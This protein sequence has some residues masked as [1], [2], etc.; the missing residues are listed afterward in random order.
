MVL[1]ACLIQLRPLHLPKT[2]ETVPERWQLAPDPGVLN[3]PGA[4]PRSLTRQKL[5]PGAARPA[6]WLEA[7]AQVLVSSG[8]GLLVRRQ[9]AVATAYWLRN[10]HPQPGATASFCCCQSAAK[11][12]SLPDLVLQLQV[13][14]LAGK[15]DASGSL[16][17]CE[18]TIKAMRSRAFT[19]ACL[20]S[21]WAPASAAA[22]D[23]STCWRRQ[24]SF[25]LAP[26]SV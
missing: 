6:L 21:S 15:D 11:Q 19:L 24:T 8:P 26:S 20:T 3:A 23:I 14:V 16:Y 25:L 7:R 1:L 22:D 18:V 12:R 10:L 17:P 4:G 5:E 9:Q 2:R 13:R